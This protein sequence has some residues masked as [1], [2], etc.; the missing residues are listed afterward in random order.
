MNR[1]IIC[2]V[3]T[4]IISINISFSQ[5]KEILIVGTMHTIP[6]IVKHNYK[7]LLKHALKYNPDK[8]FAEAPK[9]ND[10]ES[11]EY[12]KNG[13]S[14]NYKKFY[15]INDSLKKVYKFNKHK[16]Q[17]LLEKDFDKLRKEDL[18]ILIQNFIYSRDFANYDFYKYILKYGIQGAKKPTRHEDGDLTY[19][20]ALKLNIKKIKSMDYQAKNGLYHKAWKKCAKEGRN[21]GDNKI[22]KKLNKKHYRRAI[23][24]A[25]FRRLGYYNNSK[26]S[27]E[28][29][30]RLSSFTY[31]KNKTKGCKKAEEYWRMRNEGITH[32]IAKEVINSSEKRNIVFIGGAHIY[33]LKEAFKKLYP[34]LKVKFLKI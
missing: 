11:W 6:K 33:G 18:K 26:F 21:N 20:L 12:L 27:A 29:L 10:N 34:N 3:L 25:V 23:I 22:N 7:P 31:V 17:Q 13:W 19:K 1:I 4:I 24:P 9:A 2:F 8:I 16:H 5:E 15:Y 14:K 28:T 30:H 32:N